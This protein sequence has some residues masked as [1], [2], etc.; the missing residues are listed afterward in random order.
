MATRRSRAPDG[1]Q[2][3]FFSTR[4]GAGVFA[5]A[6]DGSGQAKPLTSDPVRVLIPSS[7]VLFGT[8]DYSIGLDRQYDI[9]PDGRLLM[10]KRSRSEAAAPLGVIVVLNRFEELKAR[11]PVP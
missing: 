11:V 2:V 4:E 1:Q 6:A 8:A 9:A 5:K 7:W 10:I 3:A